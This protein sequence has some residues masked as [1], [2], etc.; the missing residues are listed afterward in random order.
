MQSGFV[1]NIICLI[2]SYVNNDC[3]IFASPICL[4]SSIRYISLFVIGARYNGRLVILP[5][6]TYP[7]LEY[8]IAVCGCLFLI[9]DLKLAIRTP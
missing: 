1:A 9:Q 7:H 6:V 4:L 3:R 5:S 2:I 8:R